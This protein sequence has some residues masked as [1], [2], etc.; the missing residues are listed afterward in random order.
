MFPNV[1]HPLFSIRNSKALESNMSTNPHSV[2]QQ[3]SPKIVLSNLYS[4]TNEGIFA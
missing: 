2:L 1:V 3:R 4:V